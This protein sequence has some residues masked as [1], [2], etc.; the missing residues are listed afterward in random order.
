MEKGG[1]DALQKI[2]RFGGETKKVRKENSTFPGVPQ[3]E[4][5]GEL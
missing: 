5:K 3:G 4:R 1:E 2:H